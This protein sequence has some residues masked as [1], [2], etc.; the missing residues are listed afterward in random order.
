MSHTIP[1]LQSIFSRTAIGRKDGRISFYGAGNGRLFTENG[2]TLSKPLAR[3]HDITVH[4]VYQ[5]M[6]KKRK[7]GRSREE[8]CSER[9]GPCD[10][11]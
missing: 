1:Q 11:S 8:F 2:I 6:M 10:A 3:S 9:T 7:E 5:L 4:V